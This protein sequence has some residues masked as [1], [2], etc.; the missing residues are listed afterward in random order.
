[1]F[2]F[3]ETIDIFLFLFLVRHQNGMLGCHEKNYI[4]LKE[5]FKKKLF[6][7]IFHKPFKWWEKKAL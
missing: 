1:M 4:Q 2:F 7:K 3:K 6:F 5:T